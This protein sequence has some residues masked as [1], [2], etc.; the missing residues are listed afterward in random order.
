MEASGVGLFTITNSPFA[1]SVIKTAIH[2]RNARKRGTCRMSAI[3]TKST[4]SNDDPDPDA[5][6]A[7]VAMENT[8]IVQESEP[9]EK[10][11]AEPVLRQMD[12]TDKNDDSMGY[13]ETVQG[14]KRPLSSTDSD[15]DWKI[16]AANGYA[17]FQTL[18]ML[19]IVIKKRRTFNQRNSLE[20][21]RPLAQVRPDIFLYIAGS[22]MTNL[23]SFSL[24]WFVF[25]TILTSVD[26]Q[27]LRLPD[28]RKMAF[29]WFNRKRFDIIVFKK[30]TGLLI[31]RWK[32]NEN[33]A[34]TYIL[35]MGRPIVE[36]LLSWF[37][38]PW[39]TL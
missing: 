37:I 3:K 4:H 17:R 12:S 22:L 30:H 10:P 38:H 1:M 24:F 9:G 11:S 20:K 34:V 2:E 26:G 16:V 23:R 8:A 7:I 21:I 29:Q 13:D 31:W 18:K 6:D 27:G 19:D 5:D 35:P 39:I 25:M 15:S 14:K 36:V 32:L 33:G 28:R